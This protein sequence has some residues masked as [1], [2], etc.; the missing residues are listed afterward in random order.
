MALALASEGAAQGSYQLLDAI[1]ILKHDGAIGSHGKG[2]SSLDTGL[3]ASLVVGLQPSSFIRIGLFH[4]HFIE[5]FMLSG[6]SDQ[7]PA[8]PVGCSDAAKE[9]AI[10]LSFASIVITSCGSLASCPGR[11]GLT[12]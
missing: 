1:V 10:S 3:P 11:S 8:L 7:A 9:L 2:H 4:S 5:M 12:G 6:A